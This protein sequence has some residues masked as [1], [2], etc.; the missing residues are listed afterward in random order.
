MAVDL[1]PATGRDA[2]DFDH[3]RAAVCQS[4]VALDVGSDRPEV[5]RGSLGGGTAGDIH[6]LAIEADAHSVSRTPA[7][8]ARTRQPYLKFTVVESGSGIVVQDGRETAL[9]R[10]DMAIY[11][12]NRPYSLLL[13]DN[14][15]MA[16][17]MFPHDLL[18][19]PAEALAQVTATRLDGGTGVGALTKTCVLS[20][21]QQVPDL[22]GRIARHLFNG[23]I[24]LIGAVL[25]SS[26]GAVI[27][28]DA[29]VALMRRIL[30]YIDEHLSSPKL[31]PAQIAKAHFI[32]V[33][34]LH[35]LFSAQ[36]TTVSTV[37]RTRRLERCYDA[38]MSPR[39]A[40]RSVSAIALHHGFVEAA[41]FSRVFRAHFGVSPSTVRLSSH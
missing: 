16:V 27:A 2:L 21:A 24:E 39:E 28:E 30:D 29:R 31:N 3:Y 14:I 40:G 6:V 23:A 12:T 20:I 8:I 7:L 1:S 22:S 34:H 15:Q 37:I 10:G 18:D 36:G 26:A 38:L 35:G 25:E 9:R 4:V 33:R 11:D 41:H 32:S 17:V 5:F 19:V 13:D